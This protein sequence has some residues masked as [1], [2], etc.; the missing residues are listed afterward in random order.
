MEEWDESEMPFIY[1]DPLDFSELFHLL[2]STIPFDHVISCDAC[3]GIVRGIMCFGE[4]VLEFVKEPDSFLL[5]VVNT[6]RRSMNIWK[7]TDQHQLFK[8]NLD[9]LCSDQIV[10]LTL[11]GRRWE[12][13]T[14]DGVPFGYGTF[15]ND[16]GRREYTGFAYGNHRVCYGIEYFSDIERE[17][18]RGYFC[19]DCYFSNG[20]LFDRTGAINYEGEWINSKPFDPDISKFPEFQ[21]HRA[22][23]IVHKEFGNTPDITSIQ[24]GYLINLE[25]II[26]SHRRRQFMYIREFVLDGLP[27]LSFFQCFCQCANDS[28]DFYFPGEK[29]YGL[30]RIRNCPSL[31]KI[32]IGAYAF[33]GYQEFELSNLPLLSH[34]IVQYYSLFY[35]KR[36]EF[37]SWSLM[38][39]GNSF[40]DLPS[41][42][43]IHLGSRCFCACHDAVFESRSGL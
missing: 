12:G 27:K 36:V 28:D 32:M 10:D 19:H 1:G 2:V 8:M 33:S 38:V 6:R 29:D 43:E 25:K 20:R 7:G 9:S 23:W 31:K 34:F 41:L 35:V 16:D 17:K 40:L 22:S 26:F 3:S 13:P 18:Y 39:F 14:L 11:S 4:V 24:L 5:V 15:F 37:K 30:L 42:C 21:S